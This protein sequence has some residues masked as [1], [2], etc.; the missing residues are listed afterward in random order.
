LFLR[1]LLRVVF[2]LVGD[3]IVVV[4]DLRLVLVLCDLFGSG[5]AK[6]LE[7]VLVLLE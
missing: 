2:V 4:I 5:L 7:D 6:F 1:D 3:V